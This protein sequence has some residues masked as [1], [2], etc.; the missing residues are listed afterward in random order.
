LEKIEARFGECNPNNQTNI[1]HSVLD[2]ETLTRETLSPLCVKKFILPAGNSNALFHEL[3]SRSLLANNQ[4][5]ER[6][7]SADV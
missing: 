5:H 1:H 3:A 7:L 2:G 6:W 4:R